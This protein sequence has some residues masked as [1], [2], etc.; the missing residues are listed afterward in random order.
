MIKQEYKKCCKEMKEFMNASNGVYISTGE[1]E[2]TGSVSIDER[3][4]TLDDG[5]EF[6]RTLKLNFCPFCGMKRELLL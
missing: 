4:I 3:E 5:W 1:G 6:Y 2:C